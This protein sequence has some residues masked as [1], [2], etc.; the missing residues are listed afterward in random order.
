MTV[1]VDATAALLEANDYQTIRDDFLLCDDITNPRDVWVFQSN[2][3][4]NIQ[5]RQSARRREYDCVWRGLTE[6]IVQHESSSYDS[7]RRGL[8]GC[9]VHSQ[10]LLQYNASQSLL[11]S[12]NMVLFGEGSQSEIVL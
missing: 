1:A 12:T 5:G 6:W 9:I 4:G 11:Y 3:M 8:I 7:V 10:A 2:L